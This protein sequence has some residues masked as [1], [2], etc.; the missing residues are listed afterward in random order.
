M[1]RDHTP[2]GINAGPQAATVTRKGALISALT[3]VGYAPDDLAS[4]TTYV[5]MAKDGLV[6]MFFIGTRGDLHIGPT[7][8]TSKPGDACAALL[9]KDKT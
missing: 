1:G 8:K 5:A 2:G 9:L 6:N 3:H 4:T 7:Y